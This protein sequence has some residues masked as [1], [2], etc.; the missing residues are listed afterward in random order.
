MEKFL[1]WINSSLIF[2]VKSVPSCIFKSCMQSGHRN[3]V[4]RS[5]ALMSTE[6]F[7]LTSMLMS[8]CT[9]PVPGFSLTL[10]LRTLSFLHCIS[11]E[12]TSVRESKV[13]YLC[14]LLYKITFVLIN[15]HV[16]CSGP[17]LLSSIIKVFLRYA[18]I[19]AEVVAVG[20]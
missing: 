9:L 7:K 15:S 17:V 2:Y 13:L 12:R 6:E 1:R 11:V 8:V 4:M 20:E 3:P 10:I 14:S 19:T 16:Y 5:Q 18:C